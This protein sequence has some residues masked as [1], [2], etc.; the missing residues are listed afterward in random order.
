MFWLF[1]VWRCGLGGRTLERWRELNEEEEKI[2]EWLRRLDMTEGHVKEHLA[3]VKFTVSITLRKGGYSGPPEDCADSEFRTFPHGKGKPLRCVSAFKDS[4]NYEKQLVYPSSAPEDTEDFVYSEMHR[5]IYLDRQPSLLEIL[6]GKFIPRCMTLT[7]DL[8]K[9][10]LEHPTSGENPQ[11]KYPYPRGRWGSALW[12]TWY[13]SDLSPSE[14]SKD[15][16][17]KR[18]LGAEDALN[19]FKWGFPASPEQVP[20]GVLDKAGPI[21]LL[22][23]WVE[24]ILCLAL[25]KVHPLLHASKLPLSADGE[26]GCPPGSDAKDP[27]GP[28]YL[29]E[30]EADFPHDEDGPSY[31]DSNDVEVRFSPNSLAEAT[32]HAFDMLRAWAEWKPVSTNGTKA[33]AGT[34]NKTDSSTNPQ[35][36]KNK[37]STGKG[38]AQAKIVAALTLHHKYENGQCDK[39]TGP[40]RVNELA[41]LAVVSKSTASTFFRKEFGNGRFEYNRTC[42]NYKELVNY[43]R[44][45]NGEKPTARTHSHN[46]EMQEGD[47]NELDHY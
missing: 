8:N 14:L 47:S 12:K 15:G 16:H 2:Q 41:R 17:S 7:M 32:H 3:D 35:G 38:E 11:E 13:Y 6:N 37:R 9:F 33:E 20:Q 36:T 18:V 45:V 19:A 30:D 34:P 28:Y 26:P 44:R 42:D 23:G 22:S 4:F 10:T 29:E 43:L 25:K 39:S 21:Y 46:P 24:V 40:I 31:K 5:W 27:D 1:L